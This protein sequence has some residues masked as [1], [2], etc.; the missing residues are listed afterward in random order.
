MKEDEIRA[1]LKSLRAELEAGTDREK[2][3][4]LLSEL[5][6]QIESPGKTEPPSTLLESLRKE[7]E[8][9]ELEHPRAVA[10]LNRIMVSLGNTGI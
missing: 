5:E 10:L 7:A 4:Q 8:Q 3:A 1:S 2:L 6:E 9:F